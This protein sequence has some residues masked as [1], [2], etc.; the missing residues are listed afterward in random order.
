MVSIIN[1]IN[2]KEVYSMIPQPILDRL[3]SSR[4]LSFKFI[5]PPECTV[6]SRII[7]DARQTMSYLTKKKEIII[8][9]GK[10]EIALDEFF[11]VILTVSVNLNL[12]LTDDLPALKPFKRKF[13]KFNTALENIYDK[14]NNDIHNMLLSIA[15]YYNDIGK[16]L[17]WLKHELN[18]TPGLES[19]IVNVIC[20]NSYKIESS[21]IM[22][23]DNPRPI[24][25]MGYALP[26]YG[27]D[28]VAIKPS[29]LNIE[30][31][32]ADIP[33]DVYILTHALQRLSERIDCFPTGSIHYNMFIS[34]KDPKVFYDGNQNILIEYRYFGTRA[35]YFRVDIIEGKIIIRTFLFITNNG[36]PEG[37]KLGNIT[38]LQKLDKK[39]LAIDRLSTFMTSDIGENDKI[40]KIFTSAGCQCLLELYEKSHQVATN[41]SKHFDSD[42]ML[43]YIGY[44]KKH[45]PEALQHTTLF[46]TQPETS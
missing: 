20:I 22:V 1:T 5:V 28:W 42:L 4:T 25:R 23:D 35:G 40:R 3:Y 38:G 19:G 24:I 37:L 36:T 30:N 2:G 8:I 26:N 11:T 18:P 43:K 17:Y 21:T 10:L 12:F 14:V 15:F 6:P 13:K 31:P 39:Y 41:T 34:L 46:R 45:L 29:V 33:L 9:P 16:T 44:D 32:F 7:N 27:I